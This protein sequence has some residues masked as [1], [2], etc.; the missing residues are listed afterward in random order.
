MKNMRDIVMVPQGYYTLHSALFKSI[1]LHIHTHSWS[2]YWKKHLTCIRCHFL[3]WPWY[4]A[5]SECSPT[6]T[7]GL[8][9][10]LLPLHPIMCPYCLYWNPATTAA[11]WPVLFFFF[12]DQILAHSQWFLSS[13]LVLKIIFTMCLTSFFYIDALHVSLSAHFF[14]ILFV[15]LMNNW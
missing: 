8:C 10:V 4:T 7:H 3:G 9:R 1:V 14:A 13:V 12:N 15:P 6:R 11:F 2:N 5:G